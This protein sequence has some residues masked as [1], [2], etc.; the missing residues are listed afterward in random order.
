MQMLPSGPFNAMF[1]ERRLFVQGRVVQKDS[2]VYH[3]N[4]DAA[5]VPAE[6][7]CIIIRTVQVDPAFRRQ[8]IFTR[9]FQQLQEDYD[10]IV[11]EFVACRGLK[12]KLEEKG[13]LIAKDRED[14]WDNPTLYQIKLR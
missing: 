6:S 2:A 8:G 3:C 9:W 11:F 5:M 4:V 1:E 14:L 13:Y 7:K 10:V 12:A